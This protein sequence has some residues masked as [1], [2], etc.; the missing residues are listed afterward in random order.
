L[1]ISVT[2]L[3]WAKN[4]TRLAWRATLLLSRMENTASQERIRQERTELD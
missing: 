3:S 2:L 1:F 4:L